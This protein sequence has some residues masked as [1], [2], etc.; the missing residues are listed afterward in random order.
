MN[1]NVEASGIKTERRLPFGGAY[2]YIACLQIREVALKLVCKIIRL[3][4]EL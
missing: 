3:S 4:I 2:L 1:M